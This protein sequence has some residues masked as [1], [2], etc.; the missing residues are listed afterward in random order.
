MKEKILLYSLVILFTFAIFISGCSK[1]VQTPSSQNVTPPTSAFPMGM[2]RETPATT[3]APTYLPEGMT[4]EKY[5]E[6]Y[7][8]LL[9]EKK[10][11]EAFAIA[12]VETRQRDTT[13]NFAKARESMPI[14]SFKV[15]KTEKPDENTIEVPVELELGGMAQGSVWITTW[16]FL[17]QDGKWVAQKTHSLPKQ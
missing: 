1:P 9:T 12:P 3:V 6:K 8:K 13:Q 16:T 14:K 4:P 10:Y 5:V 7:Y 11:G 2:G 15:L 17:K